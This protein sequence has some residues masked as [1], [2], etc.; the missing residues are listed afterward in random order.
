M[1]T[2]GLYSISERDRIIRIVNS[3]YSKNINLFGI[4]TGICPIGI[5]KL[6]SQVIYSRNPYKLIEGISYF[7]GDIS[8]FKDNKMTFFDFNF[9]EK[10][11]N[12]NKMHIEEH[13]KNPIFKLL[14][15]ELKEITIKAES[16][17]FYKEEEILGE[18]NPEGNDLGMYE[19]N[20]YL[21][22]K[23]LIAMFFSC[24][25]K[26]QRHQ[27]NTDDERRVHPNNIKNKEGKEECISSALEYYG[28]E[29]VV[30]TDY[31]K[32]INELCKTNKDEKCIYNSLWV[33]SGQ[34]FPDLP[35]LDKNEDKNAPLY[36][37]QFVDC[38]IQFWKNGGS[39]VLLGENDPYNFQVNL[40]L[41][42]LVFPNGNK[43]NFKIEGNHEGG[44]ILFG[45][46]LDNGQEL[47]SGRFNRTKQKQNNNERKSL[48]NNLKKIF[49]GKTIA[50]A[51]SR[52]KDNYKPF[53][54]FSKDYEGGVNSLFYNGSDMNNDGKGEG[55]IFID[56]SYTKFF[57]NMSSE[58]T[59]RYVQNIGGF[60]GSYERREKN[61]DF[62]DACSF[63]PE[64]VEFK[65]D[66]SKLYIYPKIPYDIVYLVDATGSMQEEI[67]SV[68]DYCK[69]I[70]EILK[71]NL[72]YY[73][74]QFGAVFYRDPIDTKGS[75]K[76]ECFGL[77]PDIVKFQNEITGIIASGGNDTPEDWVGGYDC[78]L[79]MNWR[80]GN[81]LI[82]HIADAGAHGTIYSVN[83]EYDKEGDKLD[84]KIRECI[85]KNIIIVGFKIGNEPDQSFN[86]I[87][88]LYKS[89]GNEN[90]VIITE[91]NRENKN[92]GYFTDLVVN[93]ITKVT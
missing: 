72:Y 44:N 82:I 46:E 34:K 18:G 35:D 45:Q 10:S 9:D 67:N 58:G 39:L 74:F 31:E 32:A 69:T 79:H 48:G 70:A 27:T 11:Y 75:D 40:F 93:S 19:K 83:D 37:E 88:Y 80:N 2:D 62:P 81:K 59:A 86:R 91:L 23:I 47:K 25:L 5:E 17:L 24:D 53:I 26:S 41:E 85:E 42:K 43:C 68:I 1:L 76:H 55:D 33:I 8:K 13:K 20:L 12:E 77:T 49:E 38:A 92:V 30:V 66:K 22:Q 87:K 3:C 63:R 64:K 6:F 50:Y 71:K 89:Y 61:E 60:I 54:P 51:T 73:D 78:A 28:Y 52:I 14:K 7:F 36:V 57:M 56:C 65:L 90:N 4:G 16:Y 21:G 29:T 15:E 84:K